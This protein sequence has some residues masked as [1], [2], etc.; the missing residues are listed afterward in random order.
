MF[1][2]TLLY[3]NFSL[4]YKNIILE[5]T[6][7]WLSRRQTCYIRCNI[8]TYIINIYAHEIKPNGY[9]R[10]YFSCAIDI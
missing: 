1:V 9:Q 2:Y 10:K 8:G 6:E 4:E 3:I 5:E 7:L